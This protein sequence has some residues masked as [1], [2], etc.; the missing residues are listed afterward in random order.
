M[1]TGHAAAPPRDERPMSA[2]PVPNAARARRRAA[3]VLHRQGWS[4]ELLAAV[5]GVQEST[6]RRWLRRERQLHILERVRE[7]AR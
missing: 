4:V 6:M 3:L 1:S 5:A 2:V 7:G